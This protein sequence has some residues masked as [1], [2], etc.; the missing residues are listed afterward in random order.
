M[1]DEHPREELMELLGAYALDAVADD[2]RAAIDELLDVDAEAREELARCRD[3]TERLAGPDVPPPPGL[4]EGLAARL[5]TEPQVPAVDAGVA[6]DPTDHDGGATAGDTVGS[7]ADDAGH[8]IGDVVRFPSA[9]PY[10]SRPE[11]KPLLTLAAAAAIVIALVSAAVV[12]L[13]DDPP[14]TVED[15]AGAALADGRHDVVDLAVDGVVVAQI[16]FDDE[17]SGYFVSGALTALPDDRTYQL[18]GVEG[19]QVISLGVLGHEPSTV[20]FHSDGIVDAFVLTD[21]RAGGVG[22]SEGSVV[23]QVSLT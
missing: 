9:A 11:R 2:E 16:A 15:L 6:T 8:D 13:R 18:W 21:E 10:P 12:L 22:Q 19:E 17:G 4:W 14:S 20:A 5:E 1:S 7:R 23:A 3:A